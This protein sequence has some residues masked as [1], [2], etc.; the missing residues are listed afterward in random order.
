MVRMAFAECVAEL[1]NTAHRYSTCTYCIA[2][3]FGKVSNLANWEVC[4]SR[5]YVLVIAAC[6]IIYMYFLFA[7]CL[8]ER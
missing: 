2:G 8:A 7:V 1:A 4:E 5:Q 3:N 6:R